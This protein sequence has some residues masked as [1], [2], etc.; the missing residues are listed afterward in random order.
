MKL[1]SKFISLIPDVRH[2]I[3][4]LPNIKTLIAVSA[5]MLLGLAVF[6]I[7][8]ALQDISLAAGEVRLKKTD[9]KNNRASQYSL[10]DILNNYRLAQPKIETLSNA[11]R[12]KNRALEF[13]TALEAIAF[14]QAVDQKITIGR[15]EEIA[16]TT[17]SRMPLQL[18]INGDFSADF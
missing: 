15:Y 18:V 3:D 8:P 14:E 13:I 16:S 2:G 6:V 12:T 10:S 17:I 9:L 7:F 11:L 4:R 1:I 5:L